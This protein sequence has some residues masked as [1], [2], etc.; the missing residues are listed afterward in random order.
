MTQ[1]DPIPGDESADRQLLALPFI[2]AANAEA[3][4][5]AATGRRWR[6]RF[7]RSAAC[8]A[9]PERRALR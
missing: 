3:E 8:P 9:F 7:E 1:N 5:A 6:V 2:A 4:A